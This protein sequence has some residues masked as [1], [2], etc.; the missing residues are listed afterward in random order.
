MTDLREKT[1]S[2]DDFATMRLFAD[3]DRN[4]SDTECVTAVG[5][6]SSE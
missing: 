3:G 2:N 6:V 4:G 5:G 1:W